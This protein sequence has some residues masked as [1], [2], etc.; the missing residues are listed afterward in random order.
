MSWDPRRR[1]PWRRLVLEWAVVAVA[2]VLIT[3][4][5][6]DGPLPD[7]LATVALGGVLYAALG[8]LMAKFGYQRTT[9]RRL[10]DGRA[11]ASPRSAGTSSSQTTAVRPRPAPTR[12]T[13]GGTPRRRR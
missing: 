7:A 11:S 12:R 6:S 1:V 10:R 9:L 5:W 2:M 8:V 13:G 4:V 3:V